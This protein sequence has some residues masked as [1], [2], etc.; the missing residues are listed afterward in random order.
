METSDDDEDDDL[1]EGDDNSANVERDAMRLGILGTVSHSL[2]SRLL[3]APLL[4]SVPT[5]EDYMS[6][7]NISAVSLPPPMALSEEP[8]MSGVLLEEKTSYGSLRE[9]NQRGRFLDGPS[10]YRDSRT[11]DIRRLEQ[12]VRFQPPPAAA[13]KDGALSIRDRMRKSR[14][15]Q[16]HRQSNPKS[17]MQKPKSTLAAIFDK[18]TSSEGNGDNPKSPALTN[19][20]SSNVLQT[21]PF[22]ENP[23]PAL[24]MGALSTSLTGLEMLQRGLRLGSDQDS[25]QSADEL[26]RDSN[27]HNALLSR[28]LSDPRGTARPPRVDV[29]RSVL[30]PQVPPVMP[31]PLSLSQ[32]VP[33]ASL[34]EPS[35]NVLDAM[36]AD[37]EE[38]FEM[39]L[40]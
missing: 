40:E 30:F 31:S 22:Y 35:S 23:I 10:S 5:N 4:G 8:S 16:Q 37:R 38:A 32:P 13:A 26:P 18:E 6:F 29:H 14:E 3:R 2:P 34:Q 36:D 17:S 21:T 27:G 1:G 9:S 28:S 33:A 24:P 19:L 12:R 11:G 20:D 15:Q 25:Y 7:R 39:D